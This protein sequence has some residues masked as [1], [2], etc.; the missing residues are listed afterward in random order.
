[1][2]KK[3]LFVF[4]LI[5]YKCIAQYLP[6][7]AYFFGIGKAMRGFCARLMLE[8]AGKNINV[9]RRADFSGRVEIGDNSGIGICSKI[10][11]KTVIGKNVMMGPECIIYT[12]NHAFDRT[13]IPMNEQGFTPEKPVVIE[14]D[15]WI[16][17]RVIILPGVHV[18]TGAV[19]GAGSVVTRDVESYAVI[20]GNPAKELKKRRIF[21]AG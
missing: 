13:D 20:A 16:G 17:G 11:G 14:D 6:R 10:E 3:P 21:P 8:K 12:S 5:L 18:G 15:V 7:S 1:M 4:G 2:R 19:I 9:D